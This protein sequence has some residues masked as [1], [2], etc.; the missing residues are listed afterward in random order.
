[1]IEDD[2]H[3][4][5]HHDK[6]MNKR[7]FAE[8]LSTYLELCFTPGKWVLSVSHFPDKKTVQGGSMTFT[9]SLKASKSWDLLFVWTAIGNL[10]KPYS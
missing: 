1:M 9:Q 8:S 5:D 4:D 7:I 3:A 10:I 2:E 6:T